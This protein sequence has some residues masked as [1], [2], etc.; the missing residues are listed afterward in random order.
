MP[1]GSSIIKIA[2]L[3]QVIG[4]EHSPN[5]ELTLLMDKF[6]PGTARQAAA[7]DDDKIRRFK[8]HPR[9]S[10]GLASPESVELRQWHWG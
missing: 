1:L 6:I 10:L 9:F 2:S 4:S 7:T 8:L 5:F 3:K